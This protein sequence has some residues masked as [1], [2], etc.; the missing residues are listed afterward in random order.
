MVSRALLFLPSKDTDYTQYDG[1]PLGALGGCESAQLQQ[2]SSP[3]IHLA[4]SVPIL[5]S[6]IH[7]PRMLH[8]VFGK[9]HVLPCREL[10][11]VV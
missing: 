9:S 11:V 2:V 7:T 6:T 10:Q 3:G 8:L 5:K 4:C 1:P